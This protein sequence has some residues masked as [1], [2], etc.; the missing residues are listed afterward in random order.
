MTGV[1]ASYAHELATALILN[2]LVIK[3]L[4]FATQGCLNVAPDMSVSISGLSVCKLMVT[5]RT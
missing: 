5:P 1:Y 4:L 3:S 2:R